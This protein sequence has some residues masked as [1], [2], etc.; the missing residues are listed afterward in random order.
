MEN[1]GSGEKIPA[2]KQPDRSAARGGGLLVLHEMGWGRKDRAIL[3]K[4]IAIRRKAT[5]ADSL[6]GSVTAPHAEQGE[7]KACQEE[8]T[9]MAESRHGL[10]WV[11]QRGGQDCRSA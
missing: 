3:Y 8:E 7:H 4:A 11:G 1:Q 9:G 10:P 6:V 5:M 2:R